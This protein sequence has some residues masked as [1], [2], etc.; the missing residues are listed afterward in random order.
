MEK[1]DVIRKVGEGAIELVCYLAM[2]AMIIWAC[3]CTMRISF[4]PLTDGQEV[5]ESTTN[6]VLDNT[7]AKESRY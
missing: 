6:K 1:V 4:T 3:G 7:K 2:A 5:V